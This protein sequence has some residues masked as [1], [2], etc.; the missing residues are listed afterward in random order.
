MDNLSFNKLGG[1]C[2]SIGA[3]LGFIP[4]LLQIILGGT[5]EEGVQIFGFFADEVLNGGVNSLLYPIIGVIGVSLTMFGVHSLNS[6]LQKE[7]EDALLS[8]G[9]FFIII[10]SIGYIIVWSIDYFIIWGD[11]ANATS[12]FTLEMGIIIAFA[13][14]YW[15]GLQTFASAI[16]VRKYLKNIIPAIA[17]G[18]AGLIVALHWYT[19]FTLDPN[20]AKT[21]MPLFI[22]LS[23]GQLVALVFNISVGIKMIKS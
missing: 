20:S 10:G 12:S 22:G 17:S 2:L 5:P 4:F 19:I 18:A 6:V 11:P 23:V 15:G 13:S 21:I 14:I 7:K 1:F 9:T 8:L 16:A 3:V